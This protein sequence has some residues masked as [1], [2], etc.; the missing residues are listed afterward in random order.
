MEMKSN[1]SMPAW[2]GKTPNREFTTESGLNVKFTY[3][4]IT[5]GHDECTIRV[6]TITLPDGSTAIATD[7]P[8]ARDM[9]GLTDYSMW[10]YEQDA[11][12]AA[13]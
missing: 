11:T 10:Q 12:K 3:I 13:Q 4:R 8:S 9:L 1:M 7:Y 2:V 5:P 6:W